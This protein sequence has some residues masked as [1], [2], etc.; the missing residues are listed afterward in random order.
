MSALLYTVLSF[1]NHDGTSKEYAFANLPMSARV[2]VRWGRAGLLRQSQVVD[3]ATASQR[4]RQK[5]RKGYVYI[6]DRWM[7]DDGR[8]CHQPDPPETVSL[9][10]FA[11]RSPKADSGPLI[12][13]SKINTDEPDFSF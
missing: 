5:L 8:E 6:D 3:K 1:D 4:V 2:I 12:D 10:M 9:S 11:R 7:D 13:L